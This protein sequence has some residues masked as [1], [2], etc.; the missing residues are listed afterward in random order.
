M[1]Q[2]PPVLLY[3][4]DCGICREWVNYWLGLTGEGVVYRPYQSALQDYPQLT[5]GDCRHAIQFIDD[6][7]HRYSG[8]AASF[9]LLSLVPG[10]GAA[11]WLYRYLP[12]FALLAESSYAFFARHRGLLRSGTHILYGPWPAPAR[13]ERVAGWFLRGLGL[14]Y[15]CAFISA[16]IQIEGLIGSNGLLPVGDFLDRLQGYYG[17]YAAYHAPT[18]FWLGHGDMLLQATCALGAASGLLILYQRFI[19]PALAVAFI[20]YLSLVHP[21]QDFFRFQ[22]DLL[23]LETGFLALFIRTWPNLTRWLYRWLLARFL[24]MAGIAKLTSEDAAWHGLSALGHHFETQPLPTALAWYAHQL[25]DTLLMIAT[26]FTLLLEIMLVILVFSPRRAR[27]LLAWLIIAFQLAIALTG[28]YNFFNLLTLL[29]TLWLFDDAALAR[30]GQRPQIRRAPWHRPQHLSGRLLAPVLAGLIVL[31]GLDHLGRVVFQTT[32]PAAHAIEQAISPFLIVNR[33]GLF[34]NMTT[35]RPEI[36]IEGSVDGEHWRAYTFP[37]KPGPLERPPRWNAPHQPR[38]D[39]QMWFAA[40]GRPERHSWF[41]TLL[42]R[43]LE[44][45]PGIT[46]L[47][48]SNPFPDTGPHLIRARLYHYRFTDFETRR[49]SGHWWQRELRGDYYPASTLQDIRQRPRGGLPLQH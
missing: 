48:A 26:G 4:G 38:L 46:G 12:G 17:I 1:A 30:A 24:F 40:L 8:A 42:I 15:L 29:L 36:I 16:S 35:Q 31:P 22:W 44:N 34:A 45:D 9:K 20:C 32:V 2:T 14:V 5:A 43:L 25:P 10:R 33:Y 39:W 49:S 37:Y 19:G 18:L 3:D 7:G 27:M 47:L 28:N 13:Y 21:G 11:W 6:A 41:E 23:L